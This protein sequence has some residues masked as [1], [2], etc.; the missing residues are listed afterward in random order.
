MFDGQ[1]MGIGPV[2][3]ATQTGMGCL[4]AGMGGEDVRGMDGWTIAAP[5]ESQ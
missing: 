1:V 5:E 2:E 3:T 4:M